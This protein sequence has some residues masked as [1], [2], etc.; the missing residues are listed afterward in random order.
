MRKFGA[1][2]PTE[3]LGGWRREGGRHRP[4]AKQQELLSRRRG[5]RHGG[6]RPAGRCGGRPWRRAGRPPGSAPPQ[7][8]TLRVQWAGTSCAPV[9]DREANEGCSGGNGFKGEE[10]SSQQL[11]RQNCSVRWNL[12]WIAR[13]ILLA[14]CRMHNEET[15]APTR[16][17]SREQEGRT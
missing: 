4:M 10:E 2:S 14:S 5:G 7:H 12:V 3:K 11:R 6:A 17:V 16:H 9:T 13:R 8:R 1:V 15:I